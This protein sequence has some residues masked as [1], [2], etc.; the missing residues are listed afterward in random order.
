MVACHVR[1]KTCWLLAATVLAPAAAPLVGA[2]G[3]EVQGL[4]GVT[5][6]RYSQTFSWSPPVL[7]SLPGVGIEQNGTF[8]LKATGGLALSGG[9]S[10]FVLGGVGLEAR[11]DTG[12]VS[13]ETRNARFAVRV[14]LPPPLPDLA[15]DLDLEPAV[16]NLE[17]LTPLS[18]NLRLRTPGA[19]A[20]NLSGGVSYLP[21]LEVSVVQP[22]TLGVRGFDVALGS[23]DLGDVPIRA[24]PAMEDEG[25]R[26]GANLGVGLQIRL[27][28]AV[29][30]VLDARGFLFPE[31]R[32]SWSV[33]P[34]RPLNAA[35]QLVVDEVLRQIP[36]IDFRPTLINAA[37][38]VSVSF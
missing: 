27:S 32:L 19:I 38:G 34:D 10:W 8:D 28:D 30:L 4:V 29:S 5:A 12:D 20:L 26:I 9:L 37:V 25:S 6:P 23:L 1:A 18:L 13:L 7:P 11:I 17:R 24:A 14:P 31:R 3:W 33:A 36:S 22:L 15:A 16:A 2:S 35:E 21:R